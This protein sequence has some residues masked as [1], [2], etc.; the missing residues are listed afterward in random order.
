MEIFITK[1]V[2]SF[3]VKP[4]GGIDM[5]YKVDIAGTVYTQD[6]DEFISCKI[7]R[8]L[9]E[10]FSVGNACSSIIELEIV[11]KAAIPRM[12]VIKPSS[13]E[14]N[15]YPWKPEGTFFVDV[16]EKGLYTTV[17]TGYDAML[18]SEV[19]YLPRG[20]VGT[21]PKRMSTVANEIATDVLGVQMDA[22]TQIPSNYMLEYP[23]DYSC[24]EILCT[25]ASAC[26]GN[27]IIT[28]E[29]KLLLVPLFSSMPEPTNYL[30]TEEGKAITFG[31]TRILV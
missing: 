30:V 3:C 28:A 22:R 29:N 6:D 9:F 12:A 4:W 20:S 8:L 31:G 15:S 16:Q 1:A 18:K 11:P 24:R 2:L 19:V 25:I 14:N 7:T 23:N 26:G 13:R 27:W 21:W 10:R 17:L 5:E